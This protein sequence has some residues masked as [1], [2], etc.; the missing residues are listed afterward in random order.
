MISNC[1]KLNVVSIQASA[2]IREAAKKMNKYHIGFLPVVDV[3]KKLIGIVSLPDLLSLELP[4]F[5]NLINDLDF[6]SEFGAIEMNR[7]SAEEI[8]QPV[9]TLMQPARAVAEDSGLL[10]T[11]ALMLKLNL[12]DL[13]VTNESNTLVGIVSRVDIGTTILANWDEIKELH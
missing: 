9:T 10:F 13:P 7:P 2:T 3:E 8:D 5:F 1:M 4:S 6:V 12:S 11:Y